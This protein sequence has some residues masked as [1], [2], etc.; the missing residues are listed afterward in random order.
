MRCL[1]S[2]T[3]F[4][5]SRIGCL[6]GFYRVSLRSS[7][8]F[9]GVIKLHWVFTWFYRV[10][11]DLACRLPSFTEF[12]CVLL[13]RSSPGLQQVCQV[14]QARLCLVFGAVAPLPIDPAVVRLPNHGPTRSKRVRLRF[15]PP[16]PP[17]SIKR[18]P[19]GRGR[20]Q[21]WP[22]SQPFWFLMVFSWFYLVLLGF[23]RF[24]LL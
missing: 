12:H 21:H 3:E 24:Y 10:F 4:F 16:P 1:P 5:S 14:P 13:T 15:L 18:K 11:P 7:E 17:Q 19:K 20:W 6:P 23:T 9:L 8:F 22:Q 2:F